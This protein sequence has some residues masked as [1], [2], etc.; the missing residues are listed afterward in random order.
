MTH[1][2]KFIDFVKTKIESRKFHLEFMDNIAV[3][4]PDKSGTEQINVFIY[5]YKIQSNESFQDLLTK[6][7]N[8][9]VEYDWTNNYK[10]LTHHIL[11]SI[12]DVMDI[13]KMAPNTNPPNETIYIMSHLEIKTSVIIKTIIKAS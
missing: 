8:W 7:L 13:M 5:I 10:N 9:L 2:K 1:L 11:Y 12:K 3:I 6:N 4:I